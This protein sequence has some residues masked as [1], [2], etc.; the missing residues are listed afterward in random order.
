M[1]LYRNILLRLIYA[2]C[3]IRIWTDLRLLILCSFHS[4]AL[5]L[6]I[7][8]AVENIWSKLS[9]VSKSVSVRWCKITS[10]YL[11]L[12]VQGTLTNKNQSKSDNVLDG[13]NIC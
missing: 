12:P 5:P 7:V 4:R 8:G 3:R 13:C 2:L 9:G 6:E 11:M 10:I 1:V